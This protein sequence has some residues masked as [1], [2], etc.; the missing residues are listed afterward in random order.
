MDKLVENKDVLSLIYSKLP[1]ADIANLRQTSK[2]FNTAANNKFIWITKLTNDYPDFM[3]DYYMLIED[4]E[5]HDIYKWLKIIFKQDHSNFINDFSS[6]LE[7]ALFNYDY[8]V[9]VRYFLNKQGSSFFM[10]KEVFDVIITLC[11]NNNLSG[12]PQNIVE[13][14]FHAS[15]NA[16]FASFLMQSLSNEKLISYE[17]YQFLINYIGKLPHWYR[18]LFVNNNFAILDDFY[19]RV[20]GS[21]NN[22]INS[23]DYNITSVVSDTKQKLKILIWVY[24][25]LGYLPNVTADLVSTGN[26]ELLDY[27]YE[28]SNY[29]IHDNKEFYTTFINLA[30]SNDNL[31]T[32]TWLSKKFNYPLDASY[33]NNTLGPNTFKLGK[34]LLQTGA[35]YD[36]NAYSM[37]MNKKINKDQV[38]AVENVKRLV[39]LG[40]LPQADKLVATWAKYENNVIFLEYFKSIGIE[41]DI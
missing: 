25:K 40:F 15:R 41:P 3:S 22:Y 1:N 5:P 18:N 30:L 38:K 34:E 27:Y 12:V 17:N 20:P 33:I 29:L 39:A 35:K 2:S 32:A 23:I 7:L 13:I 14:F 10:S 11:K 4:I 21:L 31:E 26:S 8:F 6:L 9:L 28:K 16:N 19:N 24:D 37:L 36:K